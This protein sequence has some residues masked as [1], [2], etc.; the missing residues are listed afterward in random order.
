MRRA[1]NPERNRP[2][3]GRCSSD[4]CGLGFPHGAEWLCNML[5]LRRWAQQVC[6]T[7][8]AGRGHRQGYAAESAG[9]RENAVSPPFPGGT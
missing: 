4:R 7:D 9:K 5:A 2:L 8:A 1:G 6:Q 3:F